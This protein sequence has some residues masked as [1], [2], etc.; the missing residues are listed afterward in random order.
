MGEVG[1]DVRG[2]C[3]FGNATGL[4]ILREVDF[5][6]Y[7]LV[8]IQTF[9]ASWLRLL[10]IPMFFRSIHRSKGWTLGFSEESEVSDTKSASDNKQSFAVC[11]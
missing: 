2:K 11:K 5:R 4:D 6:G 9:E 8:S 10:Y 3:L 7:P 1:L